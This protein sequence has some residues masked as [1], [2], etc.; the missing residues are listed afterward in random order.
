MM[1]TEDSSLRIAEIAVGQHGGRIGI[2]FA[3]GKKQPYGLTGSHDRDLDIDLDTVAA[4]GAAAVVTLMEAHELERVK[5]AD[6]GAE[7]RRRH[8]EWH[9]APIVD[10]TAPGPAFESAWPALS[11][12]LRGLLARGARVL[13]HCRGGRGR[14]GMVAA[15]LLVEQSLP[16]SE[17]VAMVRAVRP[18]AIETLAQEAWVAAGCPTSLPEPSAAREAA[19]NRAVG[20]L[21]GLAVGDALGTM[22]EFSDKPRHAVLETIVGG[23][24]FRLAPGQWTD[25]TAMAMALADSLAHDPSLDACDLMNRFVSWYRRGVYSCTGTCFDI[26]NTTRASLIRYEETGDP[27]A[28]STS[29]AASG[30][31]A[32]MRLAPV[33]IRHW[34]DGETLSAVADRQTRTT[35][36][37]PA[38]IRCSRQFADLLAQAIAGVPLNI[39]LESETAGAIEGGWRGLHRDAIEGLGYVVRS[40]Q[41]AVW[42]VARTTNF[43]SAVLL[44]ANLGNDAD[45]TAAVAGQL[46]GAIY[47][48]A[49]I[50]REWLDTL[51]W[52]ERIEDTAERLFDAGWPLS[53]FSPSAQSKF[54]ETGEG[55]RLFR[56]GIGEIVFQDGGFVPKTASELNGESSMTTS[57]STAAWSRSVDDLIAFWSRLG[58]AHVH[59][60][61]AQWVTAAGFAVDLHPVP[62]AGSLGGAKTYFLFLNPGL[63]ADDQVEEARPAFKAALRTNLAGD[64]P[65]LYLQEKHATHPGHRWARQTFG[66]DI[67]E[68]AAAHI[69]M[70]Q[71]VPYHSEKGAVASK[72]A[73][74]LPSSLAIRRF[75]HEAVLPRVRAGKAGLVVA[76]SARLWGVTEEEPSVVVYGGAEPRRAFQTRGSRGGKL[77]RHMLQ[78]ST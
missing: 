48:L 60:D 27:I 50:P 63:S 69:C 4:W 26:G 14:A 23:G 18:G 62:W 78:T 40:L 58:D 30:N 52:R 32:L 33:A 17:A 36:G 41:A 55:L 72:V 54:F 70:L 13:V 8:M 29:E 1:K 42:A 25:D 45:T 73:P 67:T 2:T 76:R 64:R 12:Q 31:G 3:P 53:Q 57:Y 7:V 75:V 20:A 19:R 71:L 51:A 16:S 49:G 15:R 77:L 38:T 24:P 65:Y 43:R 44:A 9:H 34:R 66:P 68:A 39:L 22:N 35:H 28:G 56:P 5:I 47:G 61:D 46:A 10:V 21:V 6:I 59:P 74:T 37:A 11:S